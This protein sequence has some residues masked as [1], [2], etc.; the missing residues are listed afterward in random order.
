[1]P[2]SKGWKR[3]AVKKGNQRASREVSI[4]GKYDFDLCATDSD[5]ICAT[6]SDIIV[7]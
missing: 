7:T 3:V 5:I 2:K 1:M 6:D 4:E